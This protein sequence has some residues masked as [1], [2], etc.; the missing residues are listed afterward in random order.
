MVSADERRATLCPQIRLHAALQGSDEDLPTVHAVQ[1]KM[2]ALLLSLLKMLEDGDDVERENSSVESILSF[3]GVCVQVYHELQELKE[4]D[5]GREE[6][7]EV[8]RESQI[9]EKRSRGHD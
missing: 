9:E 2:V 4:E 7:Q 8:E 6:V 3:G 1:S 5:K